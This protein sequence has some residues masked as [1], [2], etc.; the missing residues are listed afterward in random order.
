MQIR[1]PKYANQNLQ[2]KYTDQNT[3]TKIHQPK[4]TNQNTPTK[5][6]QPKY[7]NRNT[8]TKIHWPKY[9]QRSYSSHS[10]QH[11]PS[12]FTWR[13]WGKR[14][15]IFAIYALHGSA[16]LTPRQPLAVLQL[17]SGRIAK[18]AKTARWDQTRHNSMILCVSKALEYF[19][20]CISV[21]VFWLVY[22]VGV[23]W[24]VY[25]GWCILVSVFWSV[26]FG[27]RFWLA[28]FGRRICTKI[29]NHPSH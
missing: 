16:G 4:Y 17:A 14:S 12:G 2:P 9:T 27:W 13:N 10:N 6:H 11:T 28:Y 7:T 15:H 25:F 5:I 23:F 21:G 24:L 18:H 22:L 8:P 26:Y 1:R 29:E 3:L 20:W 19:G